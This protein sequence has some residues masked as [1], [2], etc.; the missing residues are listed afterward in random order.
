MP[1]RGVH[2]YAAAAFFVHSMPHLTFFDG[3]P[4]LPRVREAALCLS[5]HYYHD[6]T[7]QS[8]PRML[9]FRELHGNV[10]PCR[11]QLTL[12]PSN[13][14]TGKCVPAVASPPSDPEDWDIDRVD[15]SHP[16]AKVIATL[17]SDVAHNMMATWKGLSLSRG[18]AYAPNAEDGGGD[19]ENDGLK[20]DN[21]EPDFESEDE[22][23]LWLARDNCTAEQPPPDPTTGLVPEVDITDHTP[24]RLPPPSQHLRTWRSRAANALAVTRDMNEVKENTVVPSNFLPRQFEFHDSVDGLVLFGSLTGHLFVFDTNELKIVSRFRHSS[25]PVLGMAWLHRSP[26]LFLAG[27]DEGTI[28]LY[29]TP[30]EAGSDPMGKITE[31]HQQH[32]P[33]VR[34]TTISVSMDD[35]YFLTSGYG[36]S[37]SLYDVREGRLLKNFSGLHT[38]HLNVLKWS[39]HNPNIFLTSSFDRTCKLWDI[40]LPLKDPIIKYESQRGMV[41]AC[42]SPDD[43]R[44]LASS[45]DNEVTQYSMRSTK[46][47]LRFNIPTTSNPLNYAR[48]YYLNGGDLMVTGACVDSTVRVYSC[49]SGALFREV[50]LQ[51]SQ[52]ADP[53]SYVFCQ[54]L[55]GNPCRPFSFFCLKSQYALTTSPHTHSSDQ[56]G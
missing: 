10:M 28:R 7:T 5:K 47:S 22:D 55:R 43:S 12:Q 53:A 38:G 31:V 40:R 39:N 11:A 15:Q 19:T 37:V 42:F 26:Q 49:L 33:R 24:W 56:T 8:L 54:S 50:Q 52:T 13:R 6:E 25:T 16:Q 1:P 29:K 36:A 23:D 20:T 27:A 51:R 18:H 32:T 21:D 3:V 46:P 17:T 45:V 2:S 9:L 48:A 4:L 44:I 41:M 34:L 30:L 14:R 35:H